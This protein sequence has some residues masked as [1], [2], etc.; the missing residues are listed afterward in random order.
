MTQFL[1]QSISAKQARPLRESILRPGYPPE[2][3]VYPDDDHPLTYHSGA[4][5][6]RKLIGVAS[7]Y[8]QA[9]PFAEQDTGWRLRGMA[10]EQSYQKIGVGTALMETCFKHIIDSGGG[11]IWCNARTQV[12]PFYHSL[13]FRNYGKAFNIPENGPHIVLWRDLKE[14][15]E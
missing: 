10:V 13:G 5:H 7:I 15:L 1:L 9:P 4:F 2:L 8:Y 3:S 6:E 14:L 12:A 11:L